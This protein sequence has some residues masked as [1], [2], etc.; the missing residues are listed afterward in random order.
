MHQASTAASSEALPLS[1]QLC[2]QAVVDK[3]DNITHAELSQPSAS[4]S[5][6]ANGTVT[7][8]SSSLFTE[9]PYV[10]SM[11]TTAIRR[12]NAHTPSAT[13]GGGGVANVRNADGSPRMESVSILRNM[14]APAGGMNDHKRS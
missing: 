1:S 4:L 3:G 9:Y 12:A 11:M 8:G 14:Q 7:I 2:P 10:T 5:I 13:A 6:N